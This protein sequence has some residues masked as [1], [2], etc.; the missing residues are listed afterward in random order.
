MQV[1]RPPRVGIVGLSEQISLLLPLLKSLDYTVTAIWCK[2]VEVRNKLAEEFQIAFSAS[3]F[4]ELLLKPEVDLVYVATEPALQAEVAVK[5]LT[6]GKHCIC[7]KPPS[8]CQAEAEK[9]VS[10][11]RYYSQLINIL[12]SHLRFLPATQRMKELV[13]SGF[14]GRLLVIEVRVCMGSLINTEPYSWKCDP[15][16][17]GGV[18]NIVGSHII[19]LIKYVSGQHATKVNAC[20]KTFK[21]ETDQIHGYRTITSDDFCSF[22]LQCSNGLLASV[23][24]NTHTPHQ[25]AFEF[26][27]TGSEGRVVMK[28]MDLY[29][30]KNGTGSSEELILKQEVPEVTICPVGVQTPFPQAYFYPFVIGCRGMF[31]MLKTAFENHGNSSLLGSGPPLLQGPALSATFEDG[32]YIRTVLDGIHKSSSSG[33]WVDIHKASVTE[34]ANPF[35]TTTGIRVEGD[36]LSPKT[37]R[38]VFV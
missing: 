7:Q 35:W 13:S 25:I 33:Q 14:C 34:S 30:C 2:N 24:L 11:S 32:V 22:Q 31:Q 3:N 28:G 23:I 18:A 26:A 9:M 16:M 4:Q 27:V 15:T 20:L 8:L 38:P 6:S 21:P 5:A 10:L 36:R 1:M 12:E 17:G 37:H 19:D 29:T